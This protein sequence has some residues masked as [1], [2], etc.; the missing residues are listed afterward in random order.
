MIISTDGISI[1]LEKVQCILDCETLNSIKDVQAFLGFLNF[2]KQF[3]E[4][5][6]QRTRLLTELTKRKQYSTKFGKKQVK[7]YSFEWTEI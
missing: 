5:F 1:D 6:S 3:V 7:Y 4:Q 2:Y